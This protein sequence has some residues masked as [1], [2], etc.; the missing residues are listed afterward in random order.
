MVTGLSRGNPIKYINGVWQYENG[1]PLDKEERP[2]PR[3]G[4]MP[5]KDGS[6]ACLGHI[7]GATSACCGHGKENGYIV[8]RGKYETLKGE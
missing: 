4:K 7:K 1:T 2:C 6:D 8:I 5:N 3:C